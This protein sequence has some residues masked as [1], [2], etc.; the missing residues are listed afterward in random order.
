MSEEKLDDK[1]DWRIKAACMGSDSML[2]FPKRGE[3]TK[4][5]KEICGSCRVVSECFEDAVA[6]KEP[7]GIRGGLSTRER[8]IIMK[9]LGLKLPKVID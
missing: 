9:K 5:A 2:F 3:S 6:R 1:F 4:K 8:R 7:G